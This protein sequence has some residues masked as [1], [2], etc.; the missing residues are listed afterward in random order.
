[1]TIDQHPEVHRD[2]CRKGAI[3]HEQAELDVAIE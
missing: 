3:A 2:A 1:M